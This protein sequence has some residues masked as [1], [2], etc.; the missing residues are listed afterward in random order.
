[1]TR[2]EGVPGGRLQHLPGQ[3]LLGSAAGQRPETGQASAAACPRVV[4]DVRVVLQLVLVSDKVVTVIVVRREAVLS[5]D[6]VG[7][8]HGPSH[9]AALHTALPVLGALGDGPEGPGGLPVGRGPHGGG[10]VRVA[11]GD[12][13]AE[14][15]LGPGSLGGGEELRLQGVAGDLICKMTFQF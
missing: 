12:L 5:G 1:M 13:G 3:L 11:V 9:S 4:R 14:L 7:L 2:S 15:G 10:Q 6:G 8:E